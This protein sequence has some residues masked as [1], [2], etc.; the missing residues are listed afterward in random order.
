MKRYREAGGFT[1]IETLITL[2]ILSLLVRLALPSYASIRRDSLATQAA[3]DFNTIRAAAVAQY[4]A[5][6]SYAADAP[7]GFVPAGMGTYLPRGFSFTR[8]QYRLDWENYVV[9]D[10]LSGGVAAGQI[11]ALTVSASDSL[12]GLRILHMLGANCSHWSVGNAHTFVIQSTL[13]SPR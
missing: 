12:V 4:E 9:G 6:G 7:A 5:T 3:G 10:S 1:L 8:P 11:L 13:E 2:C